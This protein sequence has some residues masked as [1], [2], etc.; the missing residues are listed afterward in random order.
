[1]R[2]ALSSIYP[3]ASANRTALKTPWD[4]MRSRRTASP[5]VLPVNMVVLWRPRIT[6][7]FTKSAVMHPGLIKQSGKC[8]DPG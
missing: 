1:M 5:V 7:T 2:I 6:G 4:W 3:M 8:N